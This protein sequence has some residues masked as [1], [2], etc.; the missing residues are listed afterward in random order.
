MIPFGEKKTIV[1]SFILRNEG[2]ANRPVI[3]NNLIAM[4]SSNRRTDTTT[5]LKE[6]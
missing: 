3:S 2:V 6:M 5:M 4:V 1:V